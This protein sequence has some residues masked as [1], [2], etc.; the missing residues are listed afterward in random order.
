MRRH[1][2]VAA[3]VVST[4]LGCG[5]IIEV[6]VGTSESG[7]ANSGEASSTEGPEPSGGPTSGQTTQVP[8]VDDTPT[9]G[10]AD[11]GSS[12]DAAPML[13]SLPFCLLDD[14]RASGVAIPEDG[15]WGAAVVE[16]ARPGGVV[17]GLDVS[18]RVSHPRVSDLR[19]VLRAPDDTVFTLLED[20]EC[21][22]ANIDAI[23]EDAAAGLGNEQCI[24][25]VAAIA[26]AVRP[27]EG[28]AP[29]LDSAM[30]NG[31]WTL[32]ITDTRPE[33]TG[34]LEQVCVVLTAEVG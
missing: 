17:V 10:P 7:Q 29:A 3:V 15:S 8:D 6:P 24:D 31:S 30:A 12:S 13:Q 23:F 11:E 28:L 19:V 22:G 27:L 5:E 33:Q 25:G 32:E 34:T 20:P 4:A 16:V 18:L 2:T 21:D 14:P 26:G 9:S 1:W